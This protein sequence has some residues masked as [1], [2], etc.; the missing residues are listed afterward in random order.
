[1]Y[2]FLKAEFQAYASA[3]DLAFVEYDTGDPR[4]ARSLRATADAGYATLRQ[5]LS[6]PF[7]AQALTLEHRAELES[8]LFR[9]R[10]ALERLEAASRA[11]RPKPAAAPREKTSL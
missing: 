2:S 11:R 4:A 5:Y 6:N 8:A 7:Y 1:M 9:L 3:A 10:E